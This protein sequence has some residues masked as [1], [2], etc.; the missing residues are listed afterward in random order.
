MSSDEIQLGNTSYTDLFWLMAIAIIVVIFGVIW[1]STAAKRL[2]TRD[3]LDQM[4]PRSLRQ[5]PAISA[6]LVLA[7]IGFLLLAMLDIRW[8]KVTRKVP[9]VGIEVVFVLD[10]SRSML[11][12]DVAPNRLVRAK[13]MIKDTVAEMAG[14]SISLVLFAGE[15]RQVIPMTSHYDEF[16]QRLDTLGT[17]DI[18][19]GGSRLGDAIRVAKD[20]FLNQSAD[21]KAIVLLTDGEDMESR[22][23]E[24]SKKAHQD[25]GVRVFA[26]GIG[27]MDQGAPIP[28]ESNNR[29]SFIRHKGEQVVSKLDGAVL[30]RMAK[31]SDGV[32]IPAGTKQVDMA[33]FYYGYLDALP[34]TITQNRTVDNYEA[35]FQWF[36]APAVAILL[37]EMVWSA[38][39][40]VRQ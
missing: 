38:A 10:V 40:R 16:S 8:G 14:D 18:N 27:D 9:Q 23:I 4:L 34:D 24:A 13:Q 12:E 22:P 7:S 5:R 35:R 19:R 20:S 6:I 15:A 32:F 17:T 28:I 1:R 3:R 21:Q 39:L 26:I 33:D 31:N 11:A 36:L 25:E 29:R 2:A 30:K 37:L